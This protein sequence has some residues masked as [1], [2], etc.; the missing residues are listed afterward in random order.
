LT[1]Y[2][3]LR[4]VCLARVLNLHAQKS[5][6]VLTFGAFDFRYLLLSLAST[7]ASQSGY[8]TIRIS[9]SANLLAHLKGNQF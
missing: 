6:L 8:L 2:V 4:V 3:T 5:S 9:L 7:L 1:V